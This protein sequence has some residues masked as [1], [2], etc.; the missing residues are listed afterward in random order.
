MESLNYIII[1][2]ELGIKLAVNKV[3][4]LVTTEG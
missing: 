4:E 3:K 2:P 1:L